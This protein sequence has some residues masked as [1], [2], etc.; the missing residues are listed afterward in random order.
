[1]K[2][3]LHVDTFAPA[4]R[5][6][7]HAASTDPTRTALHGINLRATA[8][9][10]RIAGTNGHWLAVYE[11]AVAASAT[12]EGECILPLA[13]AVDVAR[14]LKGAKAGC[15][16]VELVGGTVRVTHLASSMSTAPVDAQ[17]A[18]FEAVIP[19]SR[20]AVSFIAVDATYLVA[21]AKAFGEFKV[22]KR[23]NTLAF[24]FGGSELDPITIQSPNVPELRV[25]LMPCREDAKDIGAPPVGVKSD[26]SDVAA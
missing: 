13:F 25:V 3:S 9:R 1:M 15:V 24:S 11:E 21:A 5:A 16:D 4:L 19:K 7:I 23:K 22:G 26:V 18:P 8:G 17:F 2:F 14:M 10:V 6:V 20:D 12:S